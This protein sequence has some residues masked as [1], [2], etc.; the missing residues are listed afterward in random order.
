MRRGTRRLGLAA[1]CG[2]CLSLSAASNASGPVPSP[3]AA[4]VA[5]PARDPG[6]PRTFSKDGTTV[7]LHQPQVDTWKDHEEITFRCAVEVTLAGET[8]PAWGVVAAEGHTSV[9]EDKTDVAISGIRIVAVRFPGASDTDAAALKAV[10]LDLLP[11]MQT[12]HVALQ[13]VM[14]YLHGQQLPKGVALNLEP[15]PIH[16]SSTPAVL[17][18]YIGQPQFRPVPNTSLM[19]AV[20]TNWVVVMDSTSSQYYLMVGPSW[21]SAP[22]PVNGPWAPAGALPADFSNLPDDDQWKSVRANVPGQPLASPPAVITSTEPAELIVT[23]GPPSYTPIGGTTLMYVS[24]P[25]MPVFLDVPTSTYYYL[26]SG[27]WFSAP[28]L[29]G[30]WAAA[31]ANLPAE[32]ARIPASSPMGF[33]LASVPGTVQARDAVLLAQVPHKSTLD[34][35]TTT[36]HVD[37]D[38]TPDFVAIPNTSLQYATNTAYAVVSVNGAYYCCHN[39]VWFLSGTPLGPWAVCTSVPAAIYTIPPSC[40]I[41]NCT[42]VKVY[43]STPT[44]VT[45]GYTSGYSGAYVA[46]TGALMFGAGMLVGAAIADNNCCWYGYHPCY[47]SYGCAPYYHYGYCGY[48]SAGYAHYGPYGGAGWAAGYNPATGTYYRGGEA[49]GPGGARWGGQAYN[50]WT[51]TYAQHT[52]GTN[53]YKSWGNSYVQQGSNWAQAGHEST[54]RGGVGYAENS[55]GA[56]AEG[57]HSNVTNSSAARTSG[58]DV[59]AGHDGNVYKNTGSGW[60][61]YDD[62]SWNQVQRPDQS[63]GADSWQQRADSRQGASSSGDLQSRWGGQSSGDGWGSHE[64]LG[65]LDRDSWARNFGNGGSS[66]WGGDGGFSGGWGGGNRSWG[67]GGGWSGGGR[68]WGGGG[69]WGSRFGGGGFRGGGF[70]R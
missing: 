58:G 17:V 14:A 6:W 51:N 53:G 65:G 52:G 69:G 2:V 18:V 61:K 12:L 54:A 57:A 25:T 22:D 11:N 47:Y 7:V 68:S 23:D 60:E 15:P 49:Y 41:Y 70:R 43:S 31:S 5:A 28:A 37:Y 39:G 55:S 32:F 3:Q 50:P 34:I 27:R 33:V 38:G 29:T 46:A 66:G 19:W 1:L 35:A 62:G 30:P 40:P 4:G 20:N 9:D 45:V 63:A 26:V 8:S 59:Y 64:T 48:Y 42:Y 67:G 13:R 56:W 36:V 44:T 21:M 10:V 16:Y 24:N